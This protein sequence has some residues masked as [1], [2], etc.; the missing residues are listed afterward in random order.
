MIDENKDNKELKELVEEEKTEELIEEPVEE[1]VEELD[2]EN[3][4]EFIEESYENEDDLNINI[5]I[6]DVN[7]LTEEEIDIVA[8]KV[9][10][11]IE[12]YENIL[13]ELENKEINFDE[14]EENGF[15]NAEYT[16]L[17]KLDKAIYKHRRSLHKNVKETGLFGNMPSWSFALFIICAL[18]T[19]VPVNPYLPLNIYAALYSKFTTDF[20][21]GVG[22]AY[23]SYFVYFGIFF[24]TELVLFIILLIKGIKNKEKMGA[25]KSYLVLFIINVLI[26]IPGLIIFLNAA[27]N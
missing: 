14:L 20:M 25:F 24:V 8:V 18:F 27:L 16:R 6:E 10:V 11:A 1:D 15:D 3:N 7:S 23:V 22:G 19:I 13:V 21:L 2:E 26:D 5:S 17:K 12:K 9:E 4:E